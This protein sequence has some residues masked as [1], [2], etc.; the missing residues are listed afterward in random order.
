MHLIPLNNQHVQF[1]KMDKAFSVNFKEIVIDYSCD[2]N[3][4]LEKYKPDLALFH[5]EEGTIG[6]IKVQ[7]VRNNDSIPKTGLATIDSS[8]VGKGFYYRFMQQYGVDDIFSIEVTTGESFPELKDNLFYIPHFIDSDINYDYKLEKNIPVLLTGHFEHKFYEWRSLVKKPI[9]D[10]FPALYFRH[11]GYYSGSLVPT[12][13]RIHGES[14]FRTLNAS[15]IVP[16]CGS[17]K[18]TVLMKHFEIPGARS[19]LV[20]DENE[21][22]KL[23]GFKDMENCVFS[24]ANQIVEKLS[25]LFNNPEILQ[26]VIDNGFEF[27]HSEHTYRQRS[28]LYQWYQLNKLK[29]TGQRIIQPSLLGDLEL[30]DSDSYKETIHLHVA[31]DVK[32]ITK[33]DELI[34][35]RN[36]YKAESV[37]KSIVDLAEYIHDAK[38]RLYLIH[39]LNGRK[40]YAYFNLRELLNYRIEAN[41]I[42]DPID[43]TI[44]IIHLLS[45]GKLER[46]IYYSKIAITKRRKELDYIRL[47]TFRLGDQNALF[48]S[49]LAEISDSEGRTDLKS[50]YYFYSDK[51][52]LLGTLVKVVNKN[53][54]GKKYTWENLIHSPK[55]KTSKEINLSDSEEEFNCGALE[56]D[57]T[58]LNMPV[59]AFH[60]SQRKAQLL[61]NFIYTKMKKV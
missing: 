30:I 61:F 24:D 13:L 44:F 14:Y 35:S 25:H 3:E 17:F 10:N 8:S 5:F 29:K 60:K 41:I 55:L 16:T 47:L 26:K 1:F 52:D 53:L 56:N 39:M 48:N 36:Y 43:L 2:Y 15:W 27:V 6:S 20:C 49:L 58:S 51:F 19:C 54:K 42:P 37:A 32:Q 28:Q 57:L 4:V 12:L 40:T 45:V 21:T 7:N 9:L 23:H 31:E 33:V 50:M 46:A 34:F 38:F 22:V 18:N 59:S 11:P